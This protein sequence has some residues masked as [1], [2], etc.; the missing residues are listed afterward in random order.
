MLPSCEISSCSSEEI[1]NQ[2]LPF[3]VQAL[4]RQGLT[5]HRLPLWGEPT[6]VLLT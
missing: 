6:D 4:N 5:H 1:A 2:P 3:F